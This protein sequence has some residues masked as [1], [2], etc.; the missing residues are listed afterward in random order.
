MKKIILVAALFLAGVAALPTFDATAPPENFDVNISLTS[1]C[2]YSKTTD[3][4]F[5]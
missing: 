2:V 3:V 4:S 5:N 1:A